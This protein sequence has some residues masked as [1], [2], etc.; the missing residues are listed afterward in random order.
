MSGKSGPAFLLLDRL[1]SFSDRGVAEQQD[2]CSRVRGDTAEVRELVKILT[3]E[4]GMSLADREP[5][6]AAKI[7]ALRS[8]AED[9]TYDAMAKM[10]TSFQVG[11]FAGAELTA[12][13]HD[14]YPSD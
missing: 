6:F 10:M 9:K 8:F 14:N 5:M 4:D 2:T 11:L 1:R 13:P 12:Y 3:V 7:V